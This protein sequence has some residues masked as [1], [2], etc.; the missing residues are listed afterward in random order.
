MDAETSESPVAATAKAADAMRAIREL[1]DALVPPENVEIFDIFGTV[2]KLRS[3][4]PARS[5]IIVMQEIDRLADSETGV[6]LGAIVSD[7][8][9]GGMAAVLR[10]VVRVST[11]PGVLAGIVRAFEIAHPKAVA[12]ARV[13]GGD[14]GTA[15]VDAADLFGVEE[16]V[17]GLL[18]FLFALG[19][20]ILA[21]VS[22]ALP[23]AAR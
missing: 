4:L 13:A 9:G 23:S 1:F 2:H 19:K 7:A 15:A 11:E 17:A 10:A 18:P 16:M 12:D 14:E 5:Q 20:R 3:R 8:R 22:Q 6:D 21:L